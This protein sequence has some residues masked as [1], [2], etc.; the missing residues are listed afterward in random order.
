MQDALFAVEELIDVP[1]EPN[2][3]VLLYGPGPEGARCKQCM[4]LLRYGRSGK[5]WNKCP[6]RRKS[7]DITK[8][9]AASTDHRV[10]WKACS[11][12]IEEPIY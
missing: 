3:C 9:G 8:L 6:L 7:T 10:N 4:R 12:F 11:Q 1:V 5:R 2:P